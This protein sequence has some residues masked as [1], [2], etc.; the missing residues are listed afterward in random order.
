MLEGWLKNVMSFALYPRLLAREF[1]KK[2]ANV[3]LGDV[4]VC[5]ALQNATEEILEIENFAS[6]N[7]FPI[8]VKA[9]DGGGGRGI[10]LIR[11]LQS[12]KTAVPRAIEES[13]SRKVFAEA[14]VVDGFRHIEVQIVG[15]GS[16]GVRHLWER[17]CSIQRRYQ[18]VV[19]IAPS[20]I[21]DR[22]LVSKVIRSAMA[23]AR[24]V[25]IL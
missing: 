12:L 1:I 15:D 6:T 25:S 8:M 10:R 13:P 21:L 22:T 11:D 23:M 18:K 3:S 20:S 5:P 2:Q 16:G 17:E 7:G 9:V 14:A 24:K 4:P 19:E